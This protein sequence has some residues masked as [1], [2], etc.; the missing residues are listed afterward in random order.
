MNK[1]IITALLLCSSLCAIAQSRTNY[2]RVGSPCP[3][4]KFSEVRYDFRNKLTATDFKGQWL[5]LDFWNRHCGSCIE[6]MPGMDSLQKTY[7]KQVKV[8][9]VG[10]TGSFY[11][12]RPDS[13]IRSFYAGIRKRMQVNL[14]IAY[15]SVVFKRLEIGACPYI[16]VVDPKG[17][18]RAVTIGLKTKDMAAFL[19][20]RKP[21]LEKAVNRKGI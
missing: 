14:P 19:A 10:Y 15:D 6:K 16:I 5:I 21:V 11:T 17:I 18:V 7:P 2:P 3:E 13:S 1:I 9:L 20:G 12:H 8:L 4:L